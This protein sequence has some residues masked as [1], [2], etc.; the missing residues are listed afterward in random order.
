[1]RQEDDIDCGGPIS[2]VSFALEFWTTEERL[3]A[4]AQGKLRDGSTT[5]LDLGTKLIV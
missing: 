3:L 1:M 4:G 5:R 2:F